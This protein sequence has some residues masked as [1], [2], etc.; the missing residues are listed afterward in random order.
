[1]TDFPN[2]DLLSL[3]AGLRRR[4]FSAAELCEA[5]LAE[6][7]RR[8]ETLRACITVTADAARAAAKAA[9]ARLAAGDASPLCGI[10]FGL[11]DNIC[12]AGIPTTCASRMLSG[13]IPPYSATAAERLC[14]AGAVLCAKCN[15]DEFSM[16]SSTENSAFYPTRN[17]RDPSRTPGGSSGGPAAAV[18]GGE[19]PF[20]LG[21]DTGGS[22]RQPAAFCGLVGMK[23]TYGTVSRHGLVAFASSLD[24]IGPLSRT[25]R[26][27]AAV[28]AAIS[29]PDGMDATAVRAFSLPEDTFCGD[30]RGLVIGLPRFAGCEVQPG[31]AA[32]MDAAADR[33]SACGAHICEVQMPAL[34]DALPAYYIL[35]SAEASSNL[36]RY[37]GVRYGLRADGADCYE[38]LY[39]TTRSAFFGAEVRRRILLGTFSLSAGHREAFYLRAK[40]AAGRV[41]AAF[42]EAFSACDLLLS[43][44]APTVAFPLGETADP[45]AMYRG[46][47]FTVPASLAGIPA[48]S[49]PCGRADGLPVG[50]QLMAP[51]GGEGLLYRVAA[52]L[53][54]VCA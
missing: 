10:P 15:M 44:T 49:L 39:S 22:I 34:T 41:R 54:E 9:D 12:T 21:S 52:L 5:A 19:L 7:S 26:D 24:Q 35:S 27:N 1:M 38:T 50:A 31:V 20:A 32:C 4:D 37:D 13:Y 16:G 2:S 8:E 45:V 25:V 18:A 3:A 42:H 36:A 40:Q 43:P 23:P 28:L 51:E 46:D 33:L 6:I 11:K 29:G 47:L 53:E 14:A 48:L 17:P 30:V